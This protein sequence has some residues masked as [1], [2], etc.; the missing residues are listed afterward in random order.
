MPEWQNRPMRSPLI[1][2][3]AQPRCR[4][5]D[6]EA[7]AQIH[8]EVVEEA[9]A[10]VVVFPELS[11]TGYHFDAAPVSTDDPLLELLVAACRRCGSVAL[12]GAPIEDDGGQRFIAI[13]SVDGDGVT[14]AYRK[15]FLGS[16]E[17]AYFQ[18]GPTPVV[19]DIDGW[20]LGLAI[21]KDT[22]LAEHAGMT[23]AL[24]IDVY[25]AGVLESADDADV[26]PSR[27]Q[28]IIADHGIWVVM[29]GFAGSTGEGF[30][31]AAGGS[32]I[33]RPDGSCV[34]FAGAEVGEIA[35]AIIR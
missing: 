34:D 27:A 11:L 29:A 14:V 19:L 6:L 16:A 2:A 18:P 7:N 10:R 3:A 21:C 31:Q 26:Q 32:A 5:Y 28:R 24:A 9:K 15:M 8:A 35:R 4:P 13:L 23:A 20:R 1:I 33:W 12:V 22:G 17:A 25:V 30:D